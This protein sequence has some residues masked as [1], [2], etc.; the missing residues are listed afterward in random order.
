[1]PGKG[2][3]SQ[4]EI[5]GGIRKATRVGARFQ[6]IR[7]KNLLFSTLI[8]ASLLSFNACSPATDKASKDQTASP[9]PEA[10]PVPAAKQSQ[11]A[12]PTP[13]Q[14]LQG[15]WQC[16]EDATNFLV[17][18]GNLRKEIADGM[19][20]W[21]EEEFVLADKCVSSTGVEGDQEPEPGKYISCPKSDMCW[22]VLQLN[23]TTLSL[24]YMGRG[25]TLNYLRVKE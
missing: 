7:M 8:L 22:Y 10:T 5:R 24:A 21:D 14:L 15:K 20:T 3:R 12:P 11:S 9:S 4:I 18:E 19:D 1:M 13:A 16:H 6:P 23:S 2:V 25:N 17:F